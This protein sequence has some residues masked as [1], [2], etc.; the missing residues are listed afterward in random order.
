MKRTVAWILI[1]SMILCLLPGVPLVASA[2]TA[3]DPNYTRWLRL[4]WGEEGEYWWETSFDHQQHSEWVSSEYG[5]P[6]GVSYETGCLTLQGA[7]LF[8]IELDGWG[9]IPFHIRVLGENTVNARGDNV[10]ALNI[11]HCHDMTIDGGGTLTMTAEYVT[12]QTYDTVAGTWSEEGG[13]TSYE[14]G[15][16][17]IRDVK[18]DLQNLRS[19]DDFTDIHGWKWA[20]LEFNGNVVL[21][22]L[23]ANVEGHSG[24]TFSGDV[25]IDGCTIDSTGLSFNCREV[26]VNDNEAADGFYLGTARITDSDLRIRD[27]RLQ[28]EWAM[29]TVVVQPGTDLIL[30][31][32]AWVE[33]DHTYSGV[34]I[35]PLYI[36]GDWQGTGQGGSL[37]MEDGKLIV[38]SDDPTRPAISAYDSHWLQSG[39]EVIVET[40]LYDRVSVEVTAGAQWLQTGGTM[41]IT[42]THELVGGEEG[43]QAAAMDIHHTCRGILSGGTLTASGDLTQAIR[44][45][46]E[47]ILGGTELELDAEQTA[48]DLYSHANVTMLGGRLDFTARDPDNSSGVMGTNGSGF[49]ITGGTMELDAACGLCSDGGLYRFLGGE[50]RIDG[51]QALQGGIDR[52]TLGEGIRAAYDDGTEALWQDDWAIPIEGSVTIKN[53][54]VSAPACILLPELV[55]PNSVVLGIPTPV[56]LIVSLTSPA[57]TVAVDLPEWAGL[58]DSGVW[59]NGR[60]TDYTVT[61]EGFSLTA[62]NGSYITFQL[63]HTISGEQTLTARAEGREFPLT[64]GCASYSFSVIP[65]TL[66][67]T[68]IF[69][70]TA[71]PGS[72]VEIYEA[73]RGLVHHAAANKLGTWQTTLRLP[74]TGEYYFYAMLYDADGNYITVSDTRRVR[75]STTATALKSL[76]VGNWIH[77]STDEAPNKYTEVVFDYQTLDASSGYYTYWPELPEFT[78][79]AAF[80][81]DTGSPLKIR[82]VVVIA[83]D[84]RNV[85]ETVTLAYDEEN[86]VWTGKEEFCGPGGIIPNRFQVQWKDVNGA[87][88][89]TDETYTDP[90]PI[91]D[92]VSASGAVLVLEPEQAGLYDLELT[93]G[94]A[95]RSITDGLGQDVPWTLEDTVCTFRAEEGEFYTVELMLGGFADWP[96]EQELTIFVG[97]DEP[98][99]IVE[100]RDRVVPVTGEALTDWTDTTFESTARYS[101]GDVLLIDDTDAVTVT[102]VRGSVYTYTPSGIDEIYSRLELSGFT[103]D[104]EITVTLGESEEELE[105]RFRESQL[106]RAY[107][108]A[109]EE[110]AAQLQGSKDFEGSIGDTD[111]KITLTDDLKG[112]QAVVKAEI[113]LS[114]TMQTKRPNR[115][116]EETKLEMTISAEVREDLTYH[117][118]S[119]DDD[120][121]VQS[122]LL[123]SD[124]TVT[125]ELGIE[126]SLGE[127]DGSSDASYDGY[128]A[129][130]LR[131][132][133]LEKLKKEPAESPFELLRDARVSFMVYPGIFLYARPSVEISWNFFGEMHLKGT[134][135]ERSRKGVSMIH[136]G[137][138]YLGSLD[139][140][141]IRKF[142]DESAQDRSFSAS[143]GFHMSAFVQPALRLG[144]GVSVLKVLDLEVWGKMGVK[145]AFDGHGEITFATKKPVD[146]QAELL[147]DLTLES[148][149]GIGGYINAGKKRITIE[150]TE[151]TLWE[152]S[153]PI[154]QFGF[155]LMPTE[156]AV[157]EEDPVY[158]SSECD[159]KNL[160]DLRLD[161]QNFK[162]V[163]GVVE[164]PKVLDQDRYTFE[165]YS[166]SGVSLSRNGQLRVHDPYS[167]FEFEV[168]VTYTGFAK[169]YRLWKIVKMKY[170]PASITLTKRT[171]DGPATCTVMVVDI[172]AR[173]I[174]QE[175]VTVPGDR[176]I[177]A[178]NGHT[179]QIFEVSPPPGYLLDR[180]IRTVILGSPEN[181]AVRP[182]GSAGFYNLPEEEPEVPDPWTVDPIGDP[183]GFVF[184]GIESNRLQG[185]TATLYRA[186]DEAG[187]N[188]RLW[189][190]EAYDQRNPLTTDIEGKYMWMVPNGWWQVRYSLEGYE[191]ARSEWMIVPPVRTEVNQNL[192]SDL[193]AQLSMHFSEGSGCPILTFSRPV[194][195]S[196]LADFT[197]TLDGAEVWADVQPVDADWSV[198]ADPLDSVICATTFRLLLDES[199]QLREHTVGFAA[200]NVVTYYGTEMA[201]LTA[202]LT[203]PAL[204]SHTVRVTGGSGSG[205]YDAGEEVTIAA[206]PEVCQVFESWS[207]GNTPLYDLW[208]STT[209]FRMPDRD[210]TIT[211]NYRWE[212]SYEDTVTAATCTEP[213]FTTHTCTRCGDSWTDSYTELG[214]HTFGDWV[215]TV[216]PTYLETGMESRTC[217]HCGLQEHRLTETLDN[218]FRDVPDGSFYHMPVLWAVEKGITN[219]TTPTTFGPN[220]QCMRAHVVTFLWRAA[221]SPEP[222]EAN[223]P[224]VDVKE[225]DFYYRAVLWA[226]E[227]GITN[228]LDA[229]HFGPFAYCNRAQVVTFLHRTLGSPAPAKTENPFADV[230]ADQWFTAPVLWA[231]ENGITNGMSATAFGPGT[232]CNRAQIVTFLYRALGSR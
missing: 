3:E 135:V 139:D 89:T 153:L 86:R 168:K 4:R 178:K 145:A 218:P 169:N 32:G 80:V 91:V 40:Q 24:M 36:N 121:A 137:D 158:V 88:G 151:F 60:Q 164:E 10:S 61:E 166:G 79:T 55:Y 175:R 29:N 227:N 54:T 25:T 200:R 209:A 132:N 174:T 68:V 9:T 195:L 94:S 162:A 114:T 141:S 31:P 221:G 20:A 207:S 210:V 64:Y 6:E 71:I 5:L 146:V 196:S 116:P 215:L 28:A 189:D 138:S 202:S 46:D 172:T 58:D 74:Q 82:D 100:Y 112:N 183:S 117:I 41:T 63:V 160:I 70:G 167:E 57:G 228:G 42:N 39:G 225:T 224:F 226:V 48:L 156:F 2:S 177:P 27:F 143:T 118:R 44:V 78:F 222:R 161:C 176:V 107:L 8:S 230:P 66:T 104:E 194:R 184:E 84:D 101:V 211:A 205:V 187:T 92:E 203:I 12:F 201:Q 131:K 193:P 163:N 125:T 13:E 123:I 229:E 23:T 53:Q 103:G 26:Q 213:G 83:T 165:L 30:G 87:A 232:I 197:A 35:F 124:E 154:K 217:S 49:T 186:D 15:L 75:Y 180:G 67:D 159:L 192:V 11:R 199:A 152:K 127:E 99:R 1:L 147:V 108:Q 126:V 128:F 50:V 212:H 56:E 219:G 105:V 231:V 129:D 65:E 110:T 97:S 179:Y 19:D 111:F 223:N 181:P 204:P 149:A 98:V 182:E 188:S 206:Q 150:G 142:T 171:P 96:E 37:H 214:E 52:F 85:S 170:T 76:T 45:D 216:E 133:F 43:Y 157:V 51:H 72:T 198:T 47:L 173:P 113:T 122:Y 22:D 14:N 140:W 93:I 185:V 102:G 144:V 190:A 77:G 115:E 21:Q 81:G 34:S 220:D 33:V 69:E 136:L 208:S 95:V 155:G 130:K 191:D 73:N 119:M 62:A 18:L 148:S 17:T 134:M 106:Y 120:R 59:V 7:D 38:R 109:L 16:M 90:R